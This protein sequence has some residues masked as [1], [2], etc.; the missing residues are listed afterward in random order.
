MRQLRF[1]KKLWFRLSR[2]ANI[3]KPLTTLVHAG[4]SIQRSNPSHILCRFPS[5][6]YSSRYFSLIFL[7][8][9]YKT[10][11]RLRRGARQHLHRRMCSS[12]T[13]PPPVFTRYF[14]S[15]PPNMPVSRQ[16]TSSPPPTVKTLQWTT[17]PLSPAARRL[18]LRMSRVSFASRAPGDQSGTDFYSL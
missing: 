6:I 11:A 13:L 18:L 7:H 8:N 16:I 12:S 3:Y 1:R 9:G 5:H 14:F 15:V 2:H 10:Q 4:V 17:P